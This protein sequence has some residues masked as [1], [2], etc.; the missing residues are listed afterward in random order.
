MF[1]WYVILKN[2]YKMNFNCQL[3]V[4]IVFSPLQ[5][6]PL[7]HKHMHD[8]I[9]MTATELKFHPLSHIT[10]LLPMLLPNLHVTKAASSQIEATIYLKM[11]W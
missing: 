8:S 5:G 2:A 1:P 4:L 6:F 11:T 7:V 10:V 3:S 9:F